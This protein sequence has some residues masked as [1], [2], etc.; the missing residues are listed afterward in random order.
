MSK[1]LPA[2]I[3]LLCVGGFVW[4]LVQLFQLRFQIGDV[5]PEYSSLR[6]DPLG[7][8]ALSEALQAIPEITVRRDF[9]AQNQLPDGEQTTY[10]HL[11]AHSFEWTSLPEELFLEI[12][13]FL[14]RGGRLV[15]TFFPE[16]SKPFSF[17]DNNEEIP[18]QKSKAKKKELSKK[19][20]PARRSEKKAVPKD[21]EEA[22]AR[23]TSL[24]ERWGVEIVFK[25]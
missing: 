5:Y 10:L 6:S 20:S 9:S 22:M 16:M 8:M 14:A 7:A 17:N 4:G 2:L 12:D 11:A 15:I 25:P 3:L 19:Q 1:R 18:L 23:R 21:R 13:R 24:K